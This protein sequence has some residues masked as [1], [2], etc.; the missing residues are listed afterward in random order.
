M[1][2][3]KFMVGIQGGDA[4]FMRGVPSKMPIADAL[5]LAAMIVALFDFDGKVQKMADEFR[6]E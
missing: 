3:F 5:E 4:V 1:D 2:N 6:R